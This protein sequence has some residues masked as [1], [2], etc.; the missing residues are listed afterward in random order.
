[1][2]VKRLKEDRLTVV[3]HSLKQLYIT[4]ML[5]YWSKKLKLH[6][7]YVFVSDESL[8]TGAPFDVIV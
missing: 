1:M 3:L 5:M 4:F 2:G 8:L 6:V 7:E